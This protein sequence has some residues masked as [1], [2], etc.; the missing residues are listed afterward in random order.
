MDNERPFH[1]KQ[2][3]MKKLTVMALTIVA[4]LTAP[5]VNAEVQVKLGQM[6]TSE[7]TLDTGHLTLV[8]DNGVTFGLYGANGSNETYFNRNAG[9]G[10]V[11]RVTDE[12]TLFGVSTGYEMKM[13][14]TGPL[15]FSVTPS[16]GYEWLRNR[17]DTD[18][19]RA[20][21]NGFKV[22]VAEREYSTLN[23]VVA[24]LSLNASY[25]NVIVSVACDTKERI[26][27]TV[28]MSL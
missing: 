21:K 9:V 14:E 28:G 17:K 6:I 13:I 25:D 1:G 24:S 4:A 23:D 3:T 5:V 12:I 11:S 2:I 19:V 22:E 8:T 27:L 7:T 20:I 26:M 16:I 18:T 15:A 10:D